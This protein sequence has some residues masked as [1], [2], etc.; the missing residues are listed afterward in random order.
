MFEELNRLAGWS[1]EKLPDREVIFITD[2]GCNGTFLLHHFIALYLKAGQHVVL[3]TVEQSFAHY[4]VACGKLGANLTKSKTE[5]KLTHVDMMKAGLNEYLQESSPTDQLSKGFS[6]KT[7]EQLNDMIHDLVNSVPVD[8]KSIVIV[9]DLSLFLSLGFPIEDVITFY[10]KMKYITRTKPASFL[11]VLHLDGSAEDL[12]TLYPN[13]SYYGTCELKL[14][15][16][17]SGYSKDVHGTLEVIQ[18]SMKNLR[19]VFERKVRQYKVTER[20]LHLFA[21]GTSKAVL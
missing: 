20:T 1:T 4:S 13:F 12:P 17:E 19:T 7:L 10:H 21:P 8:K 9:D 18:K 16:L 5:G 2:K 3:V 14:E 11:T 15:G 6:N